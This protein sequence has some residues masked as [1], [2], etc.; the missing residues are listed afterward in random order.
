MG[1]GP[2]HDPD[3]PD[4]ATAQRRRLAGARAGAVMRRPATR[5]RRDWQST[6]GR[7]KIIA[8]VLIA[9]IL[10]S[11]V[12][13]ATATSARAQDT[14]EVVEQHEPV[15]ATVQEV[16]RALSTADATAA[17]MFL[18]A[19]DEPDELRTRYEDDLAAVGPSLALA[20][21]D[22]TSGSAATREVATIVQDVPVY[23]ELVGTARAN[24]Q[25]GLPVGAAY[26][27]E[28]SHLMRE[29]VLPA[30]EELYRLQRE[31]LSQAQ[32]AVTGVPIVA[33]ALVV[34]TLV[35]LVSAQSH[36]K[37]LFKRRYNPGLLVATVAIA[38]GLVWSGVA[39]GV[40]ANLVASGQSAGSDR[41]DE[42]VETRIAVL[43]ARA[44]ELLALIAR[45][46]G[47]AYQESFAELAE[48]ISGQDGTGGRLDELRENAPSQ[49][50]GPIDDAVD[51]AARWLET[52]DTVRGL[53]DN[54]DYA[55]AVDTAV[56]TGS[57]NGSGTALARL[58]ASLAEAIRAGREEFVE[59]TATGERVLTGLPQ[60]WLVLTGLGIG[61]VAVGLRQRL[62]EYQ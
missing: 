21:F 61:G 58:D 13:A 39:L 52:H 19:G 48:Y 24:N 27:R 60:G 6:P 40:Q 3:Q 46:D 20:G 12:V 25:Q 29:Q 26:L 18:A 36:I 10:G 7:L 57:D 8:A 35:G 38:A 16:Y 59:S 28:A 22:S 34:L 30:V 33:A 23:S 41:V 53:V 56:D 1:T 17:M 49:L 45:G 62:R 9:L 31:Q 5:A 15:T 42:L 47:E 51:S 4:A 14:A 11:G 54:G 32:S 50:A 43:Q 37:A 2:R 55:E 44:D